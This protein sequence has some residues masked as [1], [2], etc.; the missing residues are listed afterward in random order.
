MSQVTRL[1]PTIVSYYYDKCID[2]ILC[3][4]M[5]VPTKLLYSSVHQVIKYSSSLLTSAVTQGE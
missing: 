5:C 2:V 3:A 4:L 1:R